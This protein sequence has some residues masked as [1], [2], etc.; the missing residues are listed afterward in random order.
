MTYGTSEKYSASVV[1]VILVYWMHRTMTVKVTMVLRQWLC[2][3]CP[4][5]WPSQVCKAKKAEDYKHSHNVV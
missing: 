4:H 1:E 2:D 5:L 3:Q